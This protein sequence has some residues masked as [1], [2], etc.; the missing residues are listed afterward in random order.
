MAYVEL[1]YH[2]YVELVY[3]GLP[4]KNGDVPLLCYFTI[5]YFASQEEGYAK[6]FWAMGRNEVRRYATE[7]R[8]APSGQNLW[9]SRHLCVCVYYPLVN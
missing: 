2:G 6:L 9:I 1:V 4:V 5:W 3:H 7:R 8:S